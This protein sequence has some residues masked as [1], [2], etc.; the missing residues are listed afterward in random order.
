MAALSLWAMLCLGVLL[1]PHSSAA[2][3]TVHEPRVIPRAAWGADESLRFDSAGREIWPPTF[4]PIQKVIIHHTETQNFDPDPAGTIRTIYK[5]DAR[6]QGLGDISY[7]FLIDEAGRIYE[8]RHSRSFGRG[9]SPTGQDQFGNG[10]SAAHAYGHNPGTV[11]IALLGS[12][13][14]LDAT[15][16]A[17]AALER[18]VAWIVATHH[19]DPF[20]SSMYQNPATGLATAFPNIAGHRDVNETSCPGQAFYVTLPRVRADVGAV[21]AGKSLA[22]PPRHGARGRRGGRKPRLTAAN[23]RENRAIERVRRRHPLVSSG[24]GHRREVALV[25]HDG[26]GPYTMQ[27]IKKL[28]ELHAAATFFDVGA[29]V[30]YFSQTAIAQRGRKFAVGNLTESYAAMTRL[31][32]T[33][34]RKE[35]GGQTARLRSL[36]IPSPKLFSPPYGAYNRDTLAVLRRLHML[37]V[38]WSVDPEDYKNPGENV[39]VQR[40]VDGA[41]P[42]SIILLH[43][44]GGDRSQTLSALPAVV[45]GLRSHGYKLVTVPR[46]ILE[47]PPRP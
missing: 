25:F 18:L 35:I 11:G 33:R 36:G 27:M 28:Q 38:L 10:V 32:R 20:G 23:R 7:N 21:I 2:A 37:M 42:G 1:S 9:E 13:D 34:Q 22:R 8:G 17:R 40:A 46:L 14:R 29:S 43:D 24:G 16:R 30:T 3:T 45:H 26:P 47:D 5:D 6:Y 41:R 15:P 44:A 39:I 12:L 4:S 31:S 19:I